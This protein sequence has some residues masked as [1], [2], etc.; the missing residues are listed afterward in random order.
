[1]TSGERSSLKKL[2]RI[3]GMAIS[4]TVSGVQPSP[5]WT[6][7]TGRENDLILRGGVLHILWTEDDHVMMT[8]PA[9]EA[10]EGTVVL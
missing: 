4:A 8:G 9:A 10:F 7:R 6:E 3:A 5:I 2:P 1:M